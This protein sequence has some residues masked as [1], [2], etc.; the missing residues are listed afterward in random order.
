MRGFV[1]RRTDEGPSDSARRHM[2]RFRAGSSCAGTGAGSN[3]R[4]GAAR[5]HVN[6]Y[7]HRNRTLLGNGPGLVVGGERLNAGLLRRF[8]ARHGF[9]PV[10]AARPVLADTLI[11][12]VLRAGEHGIGPQLFHANLL[13]S[14]LPAASA[15]PGAV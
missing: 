2:R 7:Q 13:L 6:L 11:N 8:Y 14:P 5:R 9:Q 10:W 1:V 12:A 3:L 4:V 15:G